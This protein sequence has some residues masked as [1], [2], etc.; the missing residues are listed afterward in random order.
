M[1]LNPADGLEEHERFVRMCRTLAC[2][3][4]RR[5]S[6]RQ[7]TADEGSDALQDDI[8]LACMSVAPRTVMAASRCACSLMVVL[9]IALIAAGFLLGTA[10]LLAPGIL[11]S[12][13]VAYVAGEVVRSY[14]SAVASR[15]ASSVLK[16]ATGTTN[17]MLMCLRHEPSIPR[18][19]K[20]AA[21]RPGEFASELKSALWNV[22]MGRYESFEEALH[23]VGDRWSR[24]S[25]ELKTAL[26]AM[27]TASREA[28]EAGR[29]RA[30]DRANQAIVAG[31]RMRIE[32]YALS[33]STPSMVMFGIGILLPLMVGSLLPMLS[34]DLW[35]LDAAA[36]GALESDAASTTVQTVLLMNVAFPA[37]AVAIAHDAV[38][39]HPLGAAEGAGRQIAH[40][41]V[42]A[43]AVGASGF[44]L[45]WLL[46]PHLALGDRW[47]P[48]AI[49]ASAVFPAALLLVRFGGRLPS[50]DASSSR[51]EAE[52]LLFRM[53]A[54]MVDGENFESALRASGSGGRN[55]GSG[56]ARRLCFK[57]ALGNMT[58]EDALKE[59]APQGPADGGHE[60][61][62]VVREAASKDEAAAG[63]LAM[64]L[65]AYLKDLS[66]LELT[67][68]NRLRPIMS[69]MRLTAHAMAPLVLG[70]TCVIFDSLTS[71]AA[72]SDSGAG[73]AWLLVVLGVFLAEIN[74]V[75]VYFVWGISER[76]GVRA[77]ARGMGSCIMVSEFVF[78][79]AAL[80]I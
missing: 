6:P 38:S 12:T 50:S 68:R 79:A 2:L 45:A 41:C 62:R 15:R 37:I 46:T 42:A 32:Q 40:A 65:T 3:G 20:A 35:S 73:G 30:L 36:A 54:R 31:A 80:A 13:A 43:L 26:N 11:V 78:L 10:S 44:V 21:A 33:L 14:P 77:L 71:I 4:A 63:S 48:P 75:V 56:L 22:V 7:H 29:R 47:T 24:Y 76:G 5:R 28:T 57:A 16:S 1:R 70:I 23:A 9:G 64:D 8:E 61:L 39:R 53:G 52:D 18:A 25:S 69:M 67:M 55:A 66:D 51:R 17:I 59:E 19:M 60:A 49:V 74:A 34:W 58:F 27:V 72:D